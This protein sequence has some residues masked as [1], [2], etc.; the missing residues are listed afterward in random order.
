ME[1]SY[2]NVV[3]PASYG[4]LNKFRPK[5]YTTWKWLGRLLLNF[6]PSCLST[7]RP[8]RIS[9]RHQ[10]TSISI[11]NLCYKMLICP[12]QAFQVIFKT[13]R[14]PI[15]LQTDRGTKFTNRVFQ[16]FLKENDVHF[17]TM[18][19]DE[20][21]ASI[22]ERFNRT[23]KTKMWKYFTHRETLTYMDVLPY[24]VK[25]W[26]S[27]SFRNSWNTLF[28]NSVPRSVCRRI[29]CRP[30]LKMTWKESYGAPKYRETLGRSHVVESDDGSEKTVVCF[31]RS[32]RKI[33]L[34]KVS[35]YP[36]LMTK[37]WTLRPFFLFF[38]MVSIL[39]TSSV[40]ILYTVIVVSIYNLTVQSQ[41][42]T[43]WTAL[44]SSC[45]GYLL[46]IPTIKR[47][48]GNCSSDSL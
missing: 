21:K 47:S 17:F 41:N 38:K 10:C 25:K 3:A 39:Y 24:M 12:S 46:P 28:V 7:E 37:Y 20:T 36:R 29:G 23:L 8:M 32:D 16:K 19:N 22:V 9:I 42:S 5:G 31:C 1:S 45:L 15:R 13:G 26:T 33:Q 18:Y 6:S 4:G 30:V 48:R 11:Q 14:Q 35:G 40:F 44:L 34:L 27:F 43:L 2:Y